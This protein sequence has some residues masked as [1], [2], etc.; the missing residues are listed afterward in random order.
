[1]KKENDYERFFNLI[2]SFVF[3]V[4]VSQLI[5]LVTATEFST[6][7]GGS[8]TL[9]TRWSQTIEQ[10]DQ[11]LRP[12]SGITIPFLAIMGSVT[13]IAYKRSQFSNNYL[14]LVLGL[15]LLSIFITA[16]RGWILGAVLIFLVFSFVVLKN[17]FSLL[18]KIILPGIVL[19]LLFNFVPFLKKQADLSLDRFETL[20]AL[21]GGDKTAGGSLSRLDERGPRVMKK[22]WESP[23]LG[24]GGSKTGVEFSDGHVGNQNLLMRYGIVGFSLMILFW[25]AFI[26]KLLFINKTLTNKNPYKNLP[27]LFISFMLSMILIHSTSSQ[28]FAFGFGFT[29]GYVLFFVL[30]FANFVYWEAQIEE[31]KIWL[32]K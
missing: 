32:S 11:A 26:I 20:S 13:F 4:F 29:R 31:R 1:M 14:Y 25:L 21:I 24:W 5:F 27:L 28:W 18:P 10:A 30:S 7:L 9:T 8:N 2:F 12:I 16:T 15:S 22:F 17:P 19:I 23:V 6:Y 3:F